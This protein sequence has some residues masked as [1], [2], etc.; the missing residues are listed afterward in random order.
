V[1]YVKDLE[2]EKLDAQAKKGQF[3]GYDSKSKE[4]KI[5]WLKK[6]SVTIE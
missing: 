4:Y 2:A 3:I 1:A 5:Y 6:R